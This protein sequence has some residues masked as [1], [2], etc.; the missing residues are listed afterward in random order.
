[1]ANKIQKITAN[2]WFDYQA[3]EAAKFYTSIFKNSRINRITRYGKERH[4][5][6]LEGAVMT[7]E[8]E[9]EGQKY[10]ALNGGPKYKFTE[11]ISFIVHCETQEELDY[12]WENLSEGGDEK[13]QVCGWLKDKFGVS[14]QIVPSALNDMVSDENHEKSARVMKALLDMRTKIDMEKLRKAYEG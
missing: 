1:M 12:Y 3:E 10:V 8:Y 6:G 14:W 13:A 5:S 11:A 4:E 7:V 9:L 2:L